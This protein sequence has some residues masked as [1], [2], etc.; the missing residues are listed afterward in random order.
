MILSKRLGTITLTLVLAAF[1]V[2]GLALTPVAAAG[3]DDLIITEIMYNTAS[4]EGDNYYE[5]V[6]I[7]NAGSTTVDLAGFILDDDDGSVLT[8]TNI[9]A[10]SIAPGGFAI[11]YN[12]AVTA[13]DFINSWSG[14]TLNAVPVTDWNALSNSGDQIGLW[15]NATL[16]GTRFFTTAID[17]VDYDNAAP[18]PNDDGAGSIFLADATADNSVPGN[19]LLSTGSVAGVIT[20]TNGD[21]G[22]PGSLTMVTI[23][24]AA[25]E[26]LGTEPMTGD[27]N[28]MTDSHITIEFSELVTVTADALTISCDTSGA[29]AATAVMMSGLD[30]EFDVTGDF[31]SLEMC[32]VTV[33][34][35]E[36][37]DADGAGLAA[38]YTF[39]FTTIA[40]PPPPG[41]L[42]ISEIMYDSVISGDW[43]WIELYNASTTGV[44]ISGYV[45]DDINSNAHSTANIAMGI[46]P[47][48]STAIL[49]NADGITDTAAFEAEWGATT[50][51]IP[52][53]SW[54][55]MGLNNGGDQVAL[56]A[57]FASYENDHESHTNAIDI[58][59]YDDA[60]FPDGD[61]ESIYLLDLTGDN[62]DGT[63]WA[64]SADQTDGAYIA[65]SGDIASPSVAGSSPSA[66]AIS[67][68]QIGV[69]TT[70][71]MMTLFVI[72]LISLTGITWHRS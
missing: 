44:D 36:V 35:A 42:M 72:L 49:Y 68:T 48:L 51:L 28:V 3:P 12:A 39:V 25:P 9:T 13:T 57:D 26:I 24:P 33:V 64:I 50:T 2:L 47:A 19:W 27:V 10:G 66:T 29:H 38:D 17:S 56:W 37:S 69:S 8:A 71:S 45:V 6:E 4:P 34:A 15:E 11:L 70:A 7:Y 21:V 62:N 14:V 18:W 43:E 60:A 23:L 63:N 61:G 40:P 67:L 46:V 31:A 59:N 22:S 55:A 41:D 58:V 5:W 1:V 65:T 54:G 16:Y 32:T 52:V 30:I 20:N 53:T